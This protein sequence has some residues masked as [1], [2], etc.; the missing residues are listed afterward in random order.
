MNSASLRPFGRDPCIM[1]T[2]KDL[3]HSEVVS[4]ILAHHGIDMGKKRVDHVA[5]RVTKNQ[6]WC[7]IPPVKDLV[8]LNRPQCYEPKPGCRVVVYPL[9]TK[10][11]QKAADIAIFRETG[12]A[13]RIHEEY[14]AALL[15][16]KEQYQMWS[17]RYL[18]NDEEALRVLVAIVQNFAVDYN[19]PTPDLF[20][21]PCMEKVSNALK[22]SRLRLKANKRAAEVDSFSKASDRDEY[23]RL[24]EP[25]WDEQRIAN[26]PF[27]SKWSGLVRRPHWFIDY[28]EKA[29]VNK[30]Y[31]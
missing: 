19:D 1:A 31:R 8:A 18:S 2:S 10:E 30:P 12:I 21:S 23:C 27:M 29:S 9:W 15:V 16:S 26:D 24:L 17:V 14:G 22:K 7:R 25:L 3:S 11:Q 4:R 28:L 13:R 20:L 5:D 6:E